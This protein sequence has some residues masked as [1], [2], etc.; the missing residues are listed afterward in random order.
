M[1]LNMVDYINLF[2]KKN[3]FL[4]QILVYIVAKNIFKKMFDV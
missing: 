1:K 4:N 3:I 2:E